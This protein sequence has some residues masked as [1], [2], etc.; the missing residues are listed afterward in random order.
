MTCEGE[1]MQTLRIKDIIGPIMIGPSSSHTAGA[2]RI[3]AMTRRL[4][5][6]TPTQVEFKLYGSFAHT[7]RGHGT[8]RALCA[9]ML[10]LS[11]DDL[12]IRDSLDLARAAGMD[13]V[14]TPLPDAPYDHPNTVEIVAHS[15]DGTVLTVRGE[16]IGGGAAVLRRINGVD[17][18]ITGEHASAVIRQYDQKGVLAHIA[19]SFSDRG[20][21][22]ANAR[23]Y[24]ERRG[25]MAYTVLETDSSI[26]E[27][28]CSAILAHPGILDVRI[29]P[30]DE[31]A[32]ENCEAPDEAAIDRFEARDFA[33]GAQLLDFCNRQHCTIAEA[34]REREAALCE[35]LGSCNELDDYLTR[36]LDVMS[37]SA[38]DPIAHPAQTMGGL[39]GGESRAV[40]NLRAAG[41]GVGGSQLARASAYAM[42][43]LET[44][45]SMGRIVAAPTAGSSGV[46][47]AVLLVLR[48]DRACDGAQMKDALACAAAIGYLIARNAT[49]SGAEGGCQAEIGAAAA[50]A[51]AAA[52][53]LAGGSPEQCFAAASN[54]LTNMMGLVCDPVA[55]LVEVPCQK[56]NASAAACALVSA[57]IALAGVANL[58]GFDETVQAMYRVGRALPFELRESAL[59][60]IAATPSACSWCE[61]FR[62]RG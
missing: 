53:Q 46:L 31:G 8:D 9:G 18:S 1:S 40:C 44:N 39:I 6:A 11:T 2:L 24:R 30:A 4:C 35:S 59:G 33:S 14:F 42:G 7:Y 62:N 56:R 43:V 36:V 22:I 60:G 51:A 27:S 3:A 28:V 49:V 47:P 32:Q 41:T 20:I 17:L 50:M 45:A 57:D 54:A 10:G 21:N 26:P 25:D 58:V 13:V 37:A 16:S 19:Q 61:S 55:G 52:A 34:F 5:D 23:M 48:E 38:T 12:R 29:I 15:A